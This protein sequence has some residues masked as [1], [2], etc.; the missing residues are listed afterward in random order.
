MS[1]LKV[2][3]LYCGGGGASMGLHQAL[4]SRSIKH[5]II[6]VDVRNGL[7]Y[8]FKL[9]N[10]DVFE[11]SL[12]FISSFDFIWA[13]PPCQMFTCINHM[14]RKLGRTA[15]WINLI[16]ETRE[17]LILT[18]KPFVIENVTQAPIRNDIRLCGVMFGIGVFRH[19]AF[20]I[21][22]FVCYQPRHPKHDGKIGDGKYYQVVSGPLFKNK[23]FQEKHHDFEQWKIAMETPWISVPSDKKELPKG[24]PLAEA[25]PPA[26]SRYIMN[27][28]LNNYVN[29]MNFI[30]N[31][32][33][34][35][36]RGRGA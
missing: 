10:K 24:H 36:S 35:L 29:L 22:N 14:N 16:P 18:D 23:E 15:D 30:N 2:L 27:Q 21:N 32:E 17:L 8:P 5:E 1:E 7:D 13:S 4:M 20:E 25:V 26:Y 3:D 12:K 11:L 31:R 6:G 19:R 33:I 34:S 9:I 28:Y